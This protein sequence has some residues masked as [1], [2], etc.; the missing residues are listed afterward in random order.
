MPA[1]YQWARS[2]RLFTALSV[3]DLVSHHFVFFNTGDFVSL[4]IVKVALRLHTE[5]TEG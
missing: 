2:Y 3:F 5:T 4:V 1:Y